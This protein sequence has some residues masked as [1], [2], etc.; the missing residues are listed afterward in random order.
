MTRKRNSTSRLARQVT[1]IAIAAPQVVA[2]RVARMALAGATPSAKDR[3][4]FKR[5]HTE[6]ADAF[7]Q[8]W[9]A[10][11][12][13]TARIQQQTVLTAMSTWW[14]PKS[15]A[16]LLPSAEK[17]SRDAI[18]I[19]EKGLAPVRQRAVANAKRLGRK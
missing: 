4:E 13:E 7:T 12:T 11:W 5:M 2:I 9:L 6:K 1:E 17:L 19:M 10:M 8:G 3:R 15:A 18:G 14:L 16:S